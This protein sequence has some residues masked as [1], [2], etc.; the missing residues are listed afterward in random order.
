MRG[1]GVYGVQAGL[2]LPSKRMR[3]LAAELWAGS[4]AG[5]RGGAE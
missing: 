1:R 4:G 3:A 5:I 2:L